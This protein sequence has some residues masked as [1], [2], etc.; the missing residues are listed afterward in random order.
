[1]YIQLNTLFILLN[2]LTWPPISVQLRVMMFVENH[3]EQSL[4]SL[5]DLQPLL[6]CLLRIG[7]SVQ[8]CFAF[9]QN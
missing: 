7:I 8:F 9:I 6:L 2:V 3:G 5:Q 1:M 4:L